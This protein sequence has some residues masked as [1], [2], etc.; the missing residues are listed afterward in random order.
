MQ[1]GSCDAAMSSLGQSRPFGQEDTTSGFP[2]ETNFVT[3][4]RHVSKV[5]QGDVITTL[6]HPFDAG[7]KVSKRIG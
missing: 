4:S 7:A 1:H 6:S 2:S 5:P 3:T